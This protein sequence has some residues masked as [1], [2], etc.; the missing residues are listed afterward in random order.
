M[1]LSV[2]REGKVTRIEIWGQMVVSTIVVFNVLALKSPKY[3]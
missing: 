2:T 3:I 1:N